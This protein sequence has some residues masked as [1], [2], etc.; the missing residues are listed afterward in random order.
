M[1][2]LKGRR[3]PAVS[4][5]QAYCETGA[6]ENGTLA[7]IADWAHN[8]ARAEGMRYAKVIAVQPGHKREFVGLWNWARGRS[9]GRGRGMGPPRP[10]PNC[11]LVHSL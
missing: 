4:K 3:R 10:A 8:D 6:S 7:Y 5:P 9:A 11:Q 2:R 1:P